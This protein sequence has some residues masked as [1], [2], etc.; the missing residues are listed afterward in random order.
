MISDLRDCAVD[1]LELWWVL[2]GIPGWGPRKARQAMRRCGSLEA[3]V[4]HGL[5]GLPSRADWLQERLDI[6]R[7]TLDSGV[8]A[9]S[10][11]APEFPAGWHELSD[12][13]LVVFGRGV[14][15]EQG[16]AGPAVAV[17][18]TRRCA[19]EARRIGFELGQALGQRGITV[20]SG[21]ARGVD[22]AAHRGAC[23]AGQRTV[24]ILGG[25]VDAVQPQSSIAIAD[26]MLELGGAVLSEHAT[27]EAV[28]PWHFAARN[29]LVV[30]LSSALVLVQSP[31]R[32]GAMISMQLA[33]DQGV[34]CWV[35]RPEA[36][37]PKGRWR[38]N[39]EALEE[40]PG[41]G[42]STVDGLADELAGK[43]DALKECAGEQGVPVAFRSTWKLLMAS[44]GLPLDSLMLSTG[45][46]AERMRSQLRA[47][48]MA[49]WVRRLPGEWYVPL[50]L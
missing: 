16:S 14:P 6:L 48:E 2:A 38:G 37:N 33:L 43:M 32:G 11:D 36:P 50:R 46:N 26:R 42:W 49:G 10:C 28:Q 3:A 29:R 18:G 5:R 45:W 34:P 39:L 7:R 25:P 13:P 23:F 17:V 44:R 12:A 41:M 1:R 31:A 8:W 30:G 21:L 9:M 24:G 22:A 19:Q 4:E 35:F 40:F 15:F 47:M 27:G 20:V